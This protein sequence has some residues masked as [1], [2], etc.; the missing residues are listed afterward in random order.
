MKSFKLAGSL[1]AAWS[2][3]GSNA[4][5]NEAPPYVK[6]KSIAAAGSGCPLGTIAQN[7]SADNKAFTMTFS[8]YIAEVYPDSLPADSR[9]NCSLTVDLDFPQGWTY[10]VVNF[11]YRG[12]VFLDDKVQAVAK[13]QYYFQS[14]E[15]N[16]EFVAR[17]DGESD[18][19]YHFR[20]S[21]GLDA[22]IWSPGCDGAERPLNLKTQ[23]K[24]NNNRN[25]NGEGF[26][27]VDS[28]DGEFSQTYGLIWK[29]C[30][31][32]T[33]TPPSQPST[34]W[35][36]IYD[37]RYPDAPASASI[38]NLTYNGSG[39]PLGTIAQTISS[40]KKAFT[41]L[42][43][44]FLA[45]VGPG[46]SIREG[47]KN[48]QIIL[49]LDYPGDWTYAIAHFDYRGYMYLDKDVEATQAANYYFQGQQNTL[50]RDGTEKGFKDQDYHFRHTIPVDGLN[51]APCGVKRA[52]NV[53]TSIKL[54][55]TN[56]R[57]RD[58]AGVITV[59]SQDGELSAYH[60]LVWRKCS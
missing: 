36:P 12:Y 45:E 1:V 54:R 43:D 21:L 55:N 59:D 11:D 46:V 16:A 48:C 41:L 18:Q 56:R 28:I 10:S 38:K 33:P 57:N 5:A 27:T 19:D 22:V 26:I 8:E 31:G 50:T 34:D 6:I 53:N 7:I 39:C 3:L 23:I 32:A 51:W 52:L 37:D 17:I 42:F 60:A 29:K 4:M 47:R 14:Q 24:V 44:S 20:D 40:D 2:L 49:D 35:R 15:Q 58:N 30:P 9:R 13:A 25:I